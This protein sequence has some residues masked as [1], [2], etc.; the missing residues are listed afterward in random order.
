MRSLEIAALRAAYDGGLD[1]REVIADVLAALRALPDRSIFLSR[2]AEETA[3]AEAEQLAGLPA[4]ARARRPLFGIPFAVKDNID[5]AGLPTTAG[6]AP[7]ANTPDEDAPAVAALRHAGAILIGKTNM[8]QFAT[9]LVGTRSPFGV[10]HSVYSE[11]LC[12]GGSSSGSAVAVA[13][14]LVSFA[15]G[16]DTAGSGRVPAQFNG[17]IGIKPTPGRVS[18]RGV[19]PA[20]RSLDCVSVFALTV[21]DGDLVRRQIEAFDAADPFSRR[22]EPSVIELR[23]P[24]LGILAERD[25]AR[26][27][28]AARALYGAAG[29]AAEA[30]G[31]SLETIDYR[32]FAAMAALL[33]GPFAAERAAALSAPLAAYPDAF[34]P[35]VRT[36]LEGAMK[37]SGADV[38]AAQAR[39]AALRREIVPLLQR[40]DALLLPTAPFHPTIAEIAADPIGVNAALGTYT[41]F[42]N[43]AG[44]AAVALPAG[45]DASGV[46]FGVSL[47]A[48]G[49]SDAALG[50]LADRLSRRLGVPMGA[51]GHQ[52]IAPALS[53]APEHLGLIPLAVVGAHLTGQPLNHQ[54]TDCGGRLWR[55]T[56]T[57]SDYRFYALAG[58]GPRRPGL[59]REPGFS[60]PGIEC[61]IWMMP[62]AGFGRFVAAIPRPL[63]I[64]AVVLEDGTSVRGFIAEPVAA[65]GAVEITGF[66]GWRA[67]LASL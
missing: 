24:R 56:C 37:I 66:G 25:L 45:A 9:G 65:E 8:D 38:F 57:A 36:I 19:V 34:D 26:L 28:G 18:T 63:G 55:T 14:G 62:A 6:C 59:I 41:N 43:L 50:V 1:P 27:S 23:Q 39:L 53:D 51:T 5:C 21:S 40:V 15:L 49:D 17:L 44:L 48:R 30:I 29:A 58:A 54:L 67:Y 7:F 31:A 32:P 2:V 16:T 42:V 60:G 64:G 3:L 47:I 11:A 13:L 22:A 35:S 4:E 12:A 33:Y 61:E 46:P 52:A 10:P 20:C